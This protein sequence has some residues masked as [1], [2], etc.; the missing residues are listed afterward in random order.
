M[1]ALDEA[2]KRDDCPE[3]VKA[4]HSCFRNEHKVMNVLGGHMVVRQDKA[5]AALSSLAVKWLAAESHTTVAVNALH[6]Q[7]QRAEAAEAALVTMYRDDT[8]SGTAAE[9]M[10]A[11]FI[12][13][14]ERAEATVAEQAREIA[15]LLA[16]ERRV[17][18]RQGQF[19][20]QS[21]WDDL[22]DQ[23]APA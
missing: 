15:G 7:T 2:L 1:T 9:V 5:D 12:A 3:E 10:V 8:R 11:P 16:F 23:K 14:A 6:I 21:V 22:D 18:E 19:F 17:A 13:R 4:Y 20:V